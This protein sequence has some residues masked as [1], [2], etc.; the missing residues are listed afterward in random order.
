MTVV[1]GNV[2][3][4]YWIIRETRAKQKIRYPFI[5]ARYCQVT[6]QINLNSTFRNAKSVY[7]FL[8]AFSHM[9]KTRFHILHVQIKNTMHSHE[10]SLIY[11]F[12]VI[13]LI[14]NISSNLSFYDK[15]ISTLTFNKFLY[16]VKLKSLLLSFYDKHLIRI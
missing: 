1:Y 7:G 5:W 16:I 15:D 9:S 11:S 8:H 2:K 6:W 13:F 12:L 4:V 10:Y 3:R 14:P